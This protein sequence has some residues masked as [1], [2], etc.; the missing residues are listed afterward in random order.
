MKER[1]QIVTL[2]FDNG[3]EAT[4]IGKE[5][6][7]ESLVKS[8]VRCVGIK[9]HEPIDLPEGFKFEKISEAY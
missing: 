5:Q 2:T 7:S 4:F 3:T 6:V 8:G 9:F 1:M